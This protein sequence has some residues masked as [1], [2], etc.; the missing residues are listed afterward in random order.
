MTSGTI[1]S[2]KFVSSLIEKD[3]IDKDASLLIDEMY[4]Q[5]ELRYDGATMVG[6]SVDGDLYGSVV[7]FML[8][9]LKRSVPVVIRALPITKLTSIA[10]IEIVEDIIRKCL[11]IGV[12]I[13]ALSTDN[14]SVNMNL[15]TRLKSFYP[16]PDASCLDFAILFEA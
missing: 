13:R 2:L 8:T 7:C 10:L 15:Y 1:D 12:T 3:E 16:H 6:A 9:F 11:S 14:H 4:L 5:P